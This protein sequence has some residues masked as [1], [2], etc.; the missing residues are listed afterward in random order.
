MAFKSPSVFE[1]NIEMAM[2]DEKKC[3]N[4]INVYQKCNNVIFTVIYKTVSCSS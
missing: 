3:I 1:N 2:V 4:N